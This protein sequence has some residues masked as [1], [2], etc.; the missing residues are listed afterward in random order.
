MLEIYVISEKST[1]KIISTG[2]VNRIRDK[3]W[4]KK[5]DT[6]TT[7]GYVN[8]KLSDNNLQVLYLPLSDGLPK[9]DIEK[10][11]S[12]NTKIIKKSTKT[13]KY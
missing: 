10:I 4:M 8:K 13:K 11:N 6:S 9:K 7:L 2:K 3:E 1:K 12:D 5:G